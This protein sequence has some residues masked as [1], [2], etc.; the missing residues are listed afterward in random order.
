MSISE[1]LNSLAKSIRDGIKK[2][3][4]THDA[5]ILFKPMMPHI[6]ENACHACAVGTAVLG[7]VGKD[8]PLEDLGIPLKRLLRETFTDHII[9]CPVIDCEYDH[10]H[11]NVINTI[12]FLFEHHRWE[13]KDI[14]KFLEDE[15][16]KLQ[17][18]E[19]VPIPMIRIPNKMEV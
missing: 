6:A 2:V 10:L 12:E 15:A 16:F 11:N 8:T 3:E 4:P 5:Y 9:E 17:E 7:L 19:L 1:K 18:K 13:M 14:A